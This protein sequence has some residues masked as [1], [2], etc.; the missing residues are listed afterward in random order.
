M[1]VFCL[2]KTSHFSNQSH[3]QRPITLLLARPYA[4]QL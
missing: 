3:R 2:C 4:D 1:S